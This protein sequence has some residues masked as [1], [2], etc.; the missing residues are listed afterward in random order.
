MATPAAGRETSGNSPV[1]EGL[2][3]LAYRACERGFHRGRDSVEDGKAAVAAKNTIAS[4]YTFHLPFGVSSF[5]R[6]RVPAGSQ[7]DSNA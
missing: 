1:R 2:L 7:S 6:Y 4:A 3:R 5:P